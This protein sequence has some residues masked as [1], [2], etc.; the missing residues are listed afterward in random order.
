MNLTPRIFLIMESSTRQS[1]EEQIPNLPASP[2]VYLMKDKEGTVLYVGKA[3]NLRH[4]VRTYFGKSGDT[5]YS[6]RFLMPKVHRVETLLTDTEKEALLLENT[7]IKK[8]KPRH[9]INFKDDKTY[10]SLKFSLNEE[11][12]K[13]SLVR[14]VKRDGARYFGPFASSAAVKETLRLLQQMFPL[15]T[16]RDANFKNRARPCLNF[17]IKKC[18]A[19]CCRLITPERYAELAREVLLFLE[20]KNSELIKHLRGKMI[21][22]GEALE[23]EEAASIRDQI[24]AV[25]QTLEKQKT[26]S[27]ETTDQDVF[28]FHRQGTIWEFQVL[29]FRRGLLVGNQSFPFARLNLPDEEALAA[30]VRQY[31]AEDR[32]IPQEILLPLTVE[33]QP[34]LIE[35]LAEK[36]GGRVDILAP[37]RGEKKR[38]VEMA[39]KNAANALQKKVSEKESFE[40]MLIELREK[41]RLKTLPH[42]VECFDISSLFGTL[43]VGSMVSFLD[44]R[45]DKSRYRHYKIQAPSLADDYAMMDEVLK[46]RYSKLDTGLEGPDLLIVDGG[47]GQLN[48]ALAVLAE[49][50]RQSISAIGLAKDKGK[51]FKKTGGE[52][53]DKIY[54]PNVKDP[55]LLPRSSALH[56]L[57]KIRDEAHRFAVTYHIKL[58]GQRG[59]RTILDEIPG[60]GEVK[61]KALLKH[62]GSLQKIQEAPAEALSQVESL[63]RKDVQAIFEFF[64]PQFQP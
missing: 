37:Q 58:R 33:D 47:K 5:R 51:G 7:L 31:Y 56:Y 26:A 2:G 43:A 17:Q 54:L 48:V 25:E 38:L 46:R 57:Q 20:G 34:L 13:L 53:V 35:W 39:R 42:R 28:A 6:L 1:L 40:L 21:A 45:P 41:L 27:R 8:Y 10:F 23:F 52:A 59:L 49:L 55:L 63:T 22:A 62:F 12:P 3:K 61:K 50:G 30:F 32:Y 14:R 64:H 29:F 4:R 11:F 60:I 44:G 24:Q 19:P 9:N 15:R 18:L 16:C 36:K